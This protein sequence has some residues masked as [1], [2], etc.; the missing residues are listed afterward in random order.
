MRSGEIA[1]VRGGST[2]IGR[3]VAEAAGRPT[4]G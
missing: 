1:T 3:A 2:G 4:V